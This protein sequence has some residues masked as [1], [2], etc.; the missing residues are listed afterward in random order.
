MKG[1]SKR[2]KVYVDIV[3]NEKIEASVLDKIYYDAKK[4]V[5]DCYVVE[6]SGREVIQY[7]QEFLT[8]LRDK[9]IENND[10]QKEDIVIMKLGEMY[11]CYPE[12]IEDSPSDIEAK[13]NWIS[14]NFI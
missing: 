4:V 9:M 13:F 8:K 5:D 14:N 2:M 10:I 6:V 11:Q 3:Y 7:P 12:D 1:E